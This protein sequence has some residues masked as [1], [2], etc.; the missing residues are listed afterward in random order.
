MCKK[1]R[2]KT[3]ETTILQLLAWKWQKGHFVDFVRKIHQRIVVLFMHQKLTERPAKSLCLD[4]LLKHVLS[5]ISGKVQFSTIHQ[6]FSLK[7]LEQDLP[8]VNIF[9]E[10]LREVEQL[11]VVLAATSTSLGH[12][13]G[14]KGKTKSG[15][16]SAPSDRT[17]GKQ[18]GG[19]SRAVGSGKGSNRVCVHQ[20]DRGLFGSVLPT[21][22]FFH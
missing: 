3:A 2:R 9:D 12:S 13:S 8:A 16:S 5:E 10:F 22:Y 11:D 18:D 6:K 15:A 20:H 7:L 14:D 17:N 1:L 21:Q 19:G 4:L